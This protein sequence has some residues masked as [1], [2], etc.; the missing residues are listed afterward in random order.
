M[1]PSFRTSWNCLRSN[2]APSACSRLS[3]GRAAT[4]NGRSCSCRPGRSRRNSARPRAAMRVRVKPVVADHVIHRLLAAPTLGIE[5][6]V[7]HQPRGAE[8]EGLQIT[9]ALDALIAAD[10]VGQLFG[11]KRPTLDIG[12]VEADLAQHRNVFR[13]LRQADLQVMAGNA[14]VIGQRVEAIF[15]PVG[16]DLEVDPVD[17]GA[18]CRRAWPDC[19]SRSTLRP[20]SR[21]ARGGSRVAAS[22]WSQTPGAG[23]PASSGTL[24]LRTRS[25][26]RGRRRCSD[27]PGPGRC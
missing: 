15:G 3:R 16:G 14:F 12:V 4:R 5:A 6:G 1:A 19:N 23:A 7:D 10:L 13:F 25:A 27:K 18:R 11:I 22:E 9:G 2:L 20:E 24:S 21:A 8:Q 17:R 26:A